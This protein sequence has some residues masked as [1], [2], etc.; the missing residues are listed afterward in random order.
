MGDDAESVD[1]RVRVLDAEGVHE[2][3][4]CGLHTLLAS[5]PTKIKAAKAAEMIFADTISTLNQLPESK[6]QKNV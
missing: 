1:V 4:V 6:D 5:T 3:R 2:V